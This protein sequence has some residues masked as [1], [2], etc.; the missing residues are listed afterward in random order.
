MPCVLLHA[1][2][3]AAVLGRRIEDFCI[4][5]CLAGD[6]PCMG[7]LRDKCCLP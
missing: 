4:P 2:R 3:R 7:S 6:Q 5:S 1:L